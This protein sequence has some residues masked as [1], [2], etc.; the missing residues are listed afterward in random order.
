MQF[1]L[2]LH[3]ASSYHPIESL[4]CLASIPT[5]NNI[6]SIWINQDYYF[7]YWYVLMLKM[8]DY[9][10]RYCNKLH[11]RQADWLLL[12]KSQL[13]IIKKNDLHCNS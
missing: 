6:F 10:L 2:F 1:M 7:E 4:F 9:G 12:E 3:L 11:G 13:M 8:C 5:G